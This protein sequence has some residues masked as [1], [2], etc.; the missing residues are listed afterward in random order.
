MVGGYAAGAWRKDDYLQQTAVLSARGDR[1]I[2]QIINWPLK[3]AINRQTPDQGDGT[4]RFWPHGPRRGRTGS[5]CHR[6][7]PLT[8]GASRMWWPTRYPGWGTRLA[9]YGVATAVSVSRVMAQAAFS[10][11]RSGGQHAGLPDR[12]ICGAQARRGQ[13]ELFILDGRDAEWTRYAAVLQL[14]PLGGRQRI[15]RSA[16]ALDERGQLR[17]AAA[18][19]FDDLRRRFGQECLVREL[20]IAVL[21]F[22][23]QLCELLS[24]GDRARP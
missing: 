22:L 11:R 5:Q 12:R 13:Q 15:E 4:G 14:R 1:S 19:A 3:Y 20:A 24:S 10:V 17:V 9:A 2:A 23:L 8:R 6:G 21:F 18:D 7:T 16:R